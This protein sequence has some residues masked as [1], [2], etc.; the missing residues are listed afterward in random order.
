MPRDISAQLLSRG[1]RNRLNTNDRPV[2]GCTLQF[3]SSQSAYQAGHD[4]TIFQTDIL[5]QPDVEM[6]FKS[7]RT[8]S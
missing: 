3:Q 6:V 7:A 2:K 5:D 1:T 8:C 4:E